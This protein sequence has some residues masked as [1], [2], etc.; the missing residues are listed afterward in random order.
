MRFALSHDQAALRDGLRDL[1][2]QECTPAVVRDA[3]QG[4]SQT[5][6]WDQLAGL[7][8]TGAALPTGSGGLGL[9]DVDVTAMLAEV[10]YAAVPLPVASTVAVAGPLLCAAGDP[11]G[12]VAAIAGGSCRVSVVGPTGLAPYG[13]FSDHFLWL[14]VDGAALAGR[15]RVTLADVTTV[16]GSRAMARVSGGGDVLP[17]SAAEVALAADRATLACA[18]EL[19]G[20]GRRMLDMT[21]AYVRERR[22]FGVPVGSFQAVKHQ[23]AGVLRALEFAEPA[24]MRA[25]WSCQTGAGTRGRDVSMAYLLA[26]DAAEDAAKVAIQCHGAMGYTVEY[27]LHLFAKRAWALVAEGGEVD[28]HLDRIG[29]AM[30]VSNE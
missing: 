10:G 19:V 27:D 6:L 20:V 17:V 1:L 5:G 4:K 26:H 16:D 12:L 28:P 3:W 13:R 7:G 21:V 15:D 2:S 9:S 23:L 18:A 11:G 29:E 25:A 24:V 22:Q 14:T 8:L 30:G